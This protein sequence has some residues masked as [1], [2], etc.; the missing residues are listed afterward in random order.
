MLTETSTEIL[1][2]PR[3]AIRMAL[4]EH[5]DELELRVAIET[6]AEREPNP[7]D[8]AMLAAVRLRLAE[9]QKP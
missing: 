3:K 2:D 5:R 8:V 9:G 7:G 1:I 6:R 4:E